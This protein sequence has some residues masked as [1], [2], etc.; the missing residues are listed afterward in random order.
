MIPRD[1][2]AAAGHAD[3]RSLPI[4]GFQSKSRAGMPDEGLGIA[5]VGF[6]HLEAAVAGHVGDSD[7]FVAVAMRDSVG[8]ERESPQAHLDGCLVNFVR[9]G[10]PLL[11]CQ[12]RRQ[13][14]GVFC[15]AVYAL[16]RFWVPSFVARYE[17]HAIS[18]RA[19]YHRAHNG[20][21]LMNTRSHQ[22]G[23][24]DVS[25]PRAVEDAVE[26]SKD[27]DSTWEEV[28]KRS[29]N[30]VSK[31]TPQTPQSEEAERHPAN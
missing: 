8:R 23:R 27:R 19:H 6:E 9:G 31:W 7:D 5:A 3:P 2:H 1:T 26:G 17:S 4:T 25:S 10:F 16:H 29:D 12:C 28:V 18:S 13:R 11:A 15:D 21:R 24:V 22:A 14:S 20:G 30:Q